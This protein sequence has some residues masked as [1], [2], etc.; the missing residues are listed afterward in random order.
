[1]AAATK[2]PEVIVREL[3]A[4]AESVRLELLGAAGRKP[5]RAADL[6]EEL[7]RLTARRARERERASTHRLQTLER[8]HAS[9]ARLRALPDLRSL[10]AAAGE[11]LA[12]CCEFD[13]SAVSRI[14]GS[15][16]RAETIWTQ[17]GHDPA[18]TRRIVEALGEWMPLEVGV[19]EGELVRRREPALVRAE[20]DRAEDEVM[21]ISHSRARVAAPVFAAGRVVGIVQADCFGSGRELTASDCDNIASFA[22]G[23]GLVFERTA[24]LERLDRQ[25]TCVRQAFEAT[26]RQLGRLEE[27]GTALV[28]HD[29]ESVAAVRRA[30]ARHAPP[31]SPIDNLLTAREQQVVEL[32]ATGARNRQIAEELVIS[33]ETVKS[34]ARAISRKLRASS[35]ADAV[36]RYLRLRRREYP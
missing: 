31:P 11:E 17:P 25:R 32:M 1:M 36:S 33:E 22:D 35:R 19:L 18:L 24:L 15:Y 6:G 23:F 16:W 14:R 9:L 30:A 4:E 21:V 26:E 27:E 20:A 3:G 28:R 34:H 8:I 7:A 10:V 5:A 29:R 2:T 12:H 13:R